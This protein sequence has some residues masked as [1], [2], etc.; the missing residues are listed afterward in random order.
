MIGLFND[1]SYS[2][3]HLLLYKEPSVG[4]P[5]N[6]QILLPFGICVR[7]SPSDDP[8]TSL[9]KATRDLL[10]ASPAK[11]SG[12]RE[13]PGKISRLWLH[14]PS[15]HLH[16]SFLTFYSP[17]SLPSL[18]LFLLWEVRSGSS[19]HLNVDYILFYPVLSSP[20]FP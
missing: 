18:H 14:L 4:C 6:A 15:F 2:Y 9:G 10:G 16:S 19:V 17:S 12:D 1:I 11:T 7:I 8:R 13:S 5:T 20:F 3:L